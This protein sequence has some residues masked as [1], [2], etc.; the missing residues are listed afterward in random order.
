MLV[1]LGSNI[2]GDV[3][4]EVFM[5]IDLDSE[6]NFLKEVSLIEINI[7]LLLIEK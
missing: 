6:S 7:D 3:I 2:F 1:I 4:K 5:D